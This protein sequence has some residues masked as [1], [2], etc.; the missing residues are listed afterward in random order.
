MLKA[1]LQAVLSATLIALGGA[2]AT[3]YSF[4]RKLKADMREDRSSDRAYDD[5]AALLEHYKR[6]TREAQAQIERQRL[7]METVSKE[8]NEAVQA[9]G[10]LESSVEHLEKQVA[11]MAVTIN[12]QR[13]EIRRLTAMVERMVNENQ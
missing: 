12:E 13:D 11:Q 10:R 5:L 8:R 4:W 6:E 3:A 7:E 1:E 9:T 2:V